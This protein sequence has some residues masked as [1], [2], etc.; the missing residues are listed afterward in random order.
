MHP[1]RFLRA[2]LVSFVLFALLDAFWHGNFMAGFYGQRLLVL[3]PSLAGV[4]LS[5]SPFI[6]FVEAINAVALS[7]FVLSHK[8]CGKSLGDIVWI[9]A[10][11]GFTVTGTVNFLNHALMTRWDIMIALVD[12]AWGTASGIVTALAVATTCAEPQK[13][14]GNFGFQKRA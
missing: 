10:L 8:Q 14:K 12:T 11:L 3:N 4:N 5:F 9:G 2:F 7:Y 6:L 13:A 1:T